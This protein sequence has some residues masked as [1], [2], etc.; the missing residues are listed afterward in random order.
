MVW[1]DVRDLTQ[2]QHLA[3]LETLVALLNAGPANQLIYIN[4]AR[5]FHD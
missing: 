1:R 5:A 4:L 3:Q 2:I